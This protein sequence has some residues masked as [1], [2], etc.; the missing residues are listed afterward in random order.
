MIPLTLLPTWKDY[1]PNSFKYICEMG[2]VNQNSKIVLVFDALCKHFKSL[3]M[4]K[5]NEKYCLLQ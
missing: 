2:F 4:G 3:W 5:K 1:K